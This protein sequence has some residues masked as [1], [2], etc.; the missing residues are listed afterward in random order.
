MGKKCTLIE[1]E[2][3]IQTFVRLISNGAVTSDLVRYSADN[4]GLARRTT[5]KYIADARAIIIAD[6]NQDR[7]VVV[8][9]ML[10]ISR[11]LIK[12]AMA[13]GEYNNVL[14]GMNFI[15]R[16]GGLEPK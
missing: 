2:K 4:W 7:Q 5:E 11:N 10:H 14:G 1:R 12:K 13:K 9:E 8:A 6:I 15:A 3:R 16:V